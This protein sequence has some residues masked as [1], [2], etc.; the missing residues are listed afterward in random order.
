M[1]LTRAAVLLSVLSPGV[2]A[3]P[4]ADAELIPSADGQTVYD[5]TLQVRWLA[6]ANLAAKAAK[7]FGVAVDPN[8]SMNYNTALQWLDAL[9]GVNGGAPYLGHSDW[10][11]P[12]SPTAPSTDPT[13]SATGPNNNSFGY[14][15]RN[16]ALGSLFHL[17][18]GLQYPNT[19]VPIPEAQVG[20]FVTQRS[21]SQPSNSRLSNTQLS[22]S[23]RF[24][25]RN[26]QP[27]LYWSDT[28]SGMDANGYSTFSFNTGWR[29]SNVDGHYMYV[30]PMIPGMLPGAY[31]PTPFNHL[32]VSEDGQTVYDP[33]A[34]YD[35][36]SGAKGVTWLADADLAKIEQFGAQCVNK[37]GTLCINSDGSM[38]HTTALNWVSGMNAYDGGRGWLG[39]TNWQLPP[40]DVNEPCGV[41]NSTCTGNPMGELF[42][43]Q[44]GLSV[45]T[46]VVAAREGD[47]GPFHDVQPYLYWSC[48][49]QGSDRTCEEPAA[50][51]FEWS[52]SFGN[53]FQGTDV[54]GNHLYVMVY[55]PQA[56]AA[57]LA[58]AVTAA[59]GTDPELDVFL[60]EAASTSS[61]ANAQEKA[62]LLGAFVD[63]V[64]A[65]RG[66]ALTAAQANELIALAQAVRSTLGVPRR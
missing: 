46:A 44:L 23:I 55:Y 7:G 41:S 15:C 58:A 63:H 59:R 38:S 35:S 40:A 57:A 6:D 61:A 19:A 56:P 16:S 30:L 39:Q 33:D 8:G 45:G 20:A 9:N 32:Q 36:L 37:D 10:T 66:E 21:N 25:F 14:G 52:F 4:K 17:S 60:L 12:T 5:T 18:L 1:R 49:A 62:G 54:V 28:L 65:Q 29:G 43:D 24:P 13:C 42:Y 27:Y 64:N 2:L 53:G 50:P 26:F 51:G 31:H 34:V 48:G 22:R 47:V 11:L 3:V